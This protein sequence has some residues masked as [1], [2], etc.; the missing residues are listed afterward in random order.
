M[1]TFDYSNVPAVVTITANHDLVMPVIATL[2]QPT[3]YINLSSEDSI[4]VVANSS[5]ELAIYMQVCK[6]LGVTPEVTPV[7]SAGTF[8]LKRSVRSSSE[9]DSST[10]SESTEPSATSDDSEAPVDTEGADTESETN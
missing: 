9:G 2:L 10:D 6:N 1:A 7:V 8:S 3:Q 4:T 5:T